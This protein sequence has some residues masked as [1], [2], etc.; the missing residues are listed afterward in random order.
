MNDVKSYTP[1]FQ[2]GEAMQGGAIGVVVSSNDPSFNQ[3]DE[4]QSFLGWREVFNIPAA[5]LQKLDTHGA[6]SQAFLGAL[7]MPGLTAYAACCGWPP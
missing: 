7:G 3:G 5:M 1:P 2:I 4:V 6:P